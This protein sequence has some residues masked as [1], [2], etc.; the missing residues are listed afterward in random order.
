LILVCGTWIVAALNTWQ[1]IRLLKEV[2]MGKGG[3]ITYGDGNQSKVIGKRIID[4][5]GLGAS[6]EAM[7]KGSRQIFSPSANSMIMIWWFNSPKRNVISLTAVASGLWGEKGLLTTAMAFL[8]S[9]QILK[10]FAIRQHR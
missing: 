4:I 7:W 2:Q 1:V 8:V 3:R 10:L 5:P 6:Q 9:L